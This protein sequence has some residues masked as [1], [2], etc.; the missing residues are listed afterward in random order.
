[1]KKKT[2]RKNPKQLEGINTFTP[3]LDRLLGAFEKS[4]SNIREEDESMLF[5]NVF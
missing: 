4:Q 1:M 2:R 3:C 5:F